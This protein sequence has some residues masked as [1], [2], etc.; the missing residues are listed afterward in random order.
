MTSQ[1]TTIVRAN[2]QA[3][4]DAALDEARLQWPHYF[5]AVPVE[6]LQRRW[7]I[8]LTI[9]E[10]FWENRETGR[11]DAWAAT[12]AQRSV[13]LG[14]PVTEILDGLDIL[15]KAI[16]PHL[17]RALTRKSELL[18]AWSRLDEGMALLR[19]AYMT[20]LFG[21][22]Q[23]R[24]ARLHELSVAISAERDHTR[25][26]EGIVAAARELVDAR[27]AALSVYADN[28]L[29][30][31]IHQGIS[32]TQ[33]ALIGD[34]PSGRG[35][36]GVLTDE[37]R[38]IRLSDLTH[39]SH[40][41]GF[42]PNHPEMHSFLGVPIL[43][44]DRIYGRLYLTEKQGA[45]EFSQD[46][47]QLVE[48]LA[49]HAAV[50]IENARLF[51]ES[52]SVA[53][54]QAVLNQ[55]LRVASSTLE[56]TVLLERVARTAAEAM[57]TTRC[58]IVLG[59]PEDEQLRVA[60]GYD[61]RFPDQLLTG[62]EISRSAMPALWLAMEE[63][64]PQLLRNLT[65]DIHDDSLRNTLRGLEV[66]SALHVPIFVQERV[67]GVLALAESRANHP[68]S[69]RHTHLAQAIADQIAL[70]IVNT[71]L[72]EDLQSSAISRG[73]LG[74]MLR[75]FQAVGG[76]SYSAMYSAGFELAGRVK[77]E[78]ISDYL[79]AFASMG[80]GSL[81]LHLA[82]PEHQRWVFQGDGL[83]ESSSKGDHPTGNY[84]RGYLCGALAHLFN[85]ARVACVE[86]HCQSMQDELCEFVVQVIS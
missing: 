34:L 38:T 5:P 59:S 11:L 4:Y 51:S 42:P 18:A 78:S 30:Q 83:V 20:A 13:S 63:R 72:Y 73:L 54:E 64:R 76:L 80:L 74:Q 81:V 66:S 82:D 60:G 85:D 75:D 46:D 17:E 26:L 48:M 10:D 43:I 28:S 49:A 61:S 57:G 33:R 55:V 50:A 44:H 58:V 84:T 53:T 52:Q 6:I 65:G 79:K 35:L 7:E 62:L 32:E 14:M 9:L 40:Y 41:T 24:L 86:T 69:E 77:G 39:H 25:I 22:Y 21:R 67:V 47:Q 3:I 19:G 45:L 68:F 37:R 8:L 70:A 56:Q 12:G 2:Q 15:P 23:H 36:L 16:R 29:D 31:F 71:Q 27:Y 1:L